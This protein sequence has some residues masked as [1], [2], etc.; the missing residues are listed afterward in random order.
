MTPLCRCE[1]EFVEKKTTLHKQW[2]GEWHIIE[3]VPVFVCPQCGEEY[4]D[5]RVLMNI[6]R[7]LADKDHIEKVIS[8]PVMRYK[9]A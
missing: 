8:V 2:N 6:E 7:M 4:Y 5:G 1:S 3:D 9:V